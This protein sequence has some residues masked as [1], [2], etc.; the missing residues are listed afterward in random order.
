VAFVLDRAQLAWAVAAVT[1]VSNDALVRTSEGWLRGFSSIIG[2]GPDFRAEAKAIVFTTVE[3]KQHEIPLEKAPPPG[4]VAQSRRR[5]GL[6]GFVLRVGD[7]D[8]VGRSV[9]VGRKAAWGAKTPWKRSRSTAARRS[10]SNHA[11]VLE[12]PCACVSHRVLT[13]RTRF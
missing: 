2:A 6:R 8:V 7:G 9:T 11:R 4:S 1:V 12:E 3:G 10:H 5:G 13:W